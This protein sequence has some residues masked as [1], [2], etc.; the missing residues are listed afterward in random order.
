MLKTEPAGLLIVNVISGGPASQGGIVPGDRIIEVNG[1]TTNDATPDTLADMLR[2]TEG[3]QV[4]VVARSAA[5]E[6]RRLRLTR[7]RVEVPSVEHIKIVD[8]QYG[9]GYFTW[10]AYSL[11]EYPNIVVGM[12][13]IG[14]LGTLSTYL[15][16]LATQPL[17]RWQKAERGR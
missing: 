13:V 15:V 12:L 9:I 10:N 4:D 5:G 3:T 7:R 16:K 6:A 1:K 8:S 14:G 11:I 2:G 17:L